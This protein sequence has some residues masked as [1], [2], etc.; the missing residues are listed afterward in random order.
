MNLV[1][2]EGGGSPTAVDL[3]EPSTSKFFFHNY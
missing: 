1:V 2:D 3:V